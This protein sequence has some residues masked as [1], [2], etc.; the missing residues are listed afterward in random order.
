M[1]AG[2]EQAWSQQCI[3]GVNGCRLPCDLAKEGDELAIV[4]VGK[5]GAR[6][7]P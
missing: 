7:Y 5:G 3:M 6:P 2:S 1:C 4:G